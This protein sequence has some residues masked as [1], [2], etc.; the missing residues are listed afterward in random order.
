MKSLADLKK[1]RE[2]A[3]K[4]L[5]IRDPGDRDYRVVVGM[6]TSSIATGARPVMKAIMDEVEG[7]QLNVL[8]TQTGNIGIF[9]LDPIVEVYDKKGNKTSYVRMDEDKAVQMVRSHLANGRILSAYTI[10]AVKDIVKF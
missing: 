9:N 1:I 4:E 7:L 6:D 3:Q 8:V 5:S 10:D 2:K